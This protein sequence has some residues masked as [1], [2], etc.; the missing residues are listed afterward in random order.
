ME[1]SA[2][3][4]EWVK[5]RR[6]RL[7]LTRAQVARCAGC[8]VSALRK[9]EGDERRP[10]LQLAGLLANCLQIADDTRDIFLQVARGNAP[11]AR[12]AAVADG[13]DGAS[14]STPGRLPHSPVPLVGRETELAA[15][16]RL[17]HAPDSRLVTI[18]GPGGIGKTRLAL[19]VAAG[20]SHRFPQGVAF[21]SLASL[22]SPQSIPLAIAEA[23]GFAFSG[24]LDPQAQLL[25]HLAPQSLLLVLD[26]LEHLLDG[27]GL[28]A[29]IV[30]QAPAV[31]LLVTS[32]ERLNLAGEWVFDLQGLP[33]PPPGQVEET[34][35]YSAVALF[36]QTARHVQASFSLPADE[37]PAV[38]RICQLVEGMPLAIELAAAWVRVLSCA[39]IADEIEGSLDF[40]AGAMRDAPPRQRS[41]RAAFDHSWSLLA[42]DERR[43]L[44]RLSVFQGG[45]R[46]QAAECIAGAT[47]PL[48][49][50]L[51]NKSLLRRAGDGR[52]DLHEVIRQYALAHL[53]ARGDEEVETRSRHSHFYLDLLGDREK[54][55]RS[56][57]LRRTLRELMGEIDNVRAAWAWGIEQHVGQD[58]APAVRTL[59]CMFELAGWLGEGV[60]MLEKAV[61]H[62][63]AHMEDALWRRVAGEALAQQGLLFFRR[64]RF[65]EAKARL[66]ESLEL[67]YPFNEARLLMPALLFYGVINQLDGNLDRSECLM[68]EA[69]SCARAAGEPWY[70]AYAA[71]NL[72]YV[73]SLRGDYQQGYEQMVAS[74]ALWRAVG[75]PRSIALGL[76][77]LCPTMIQLG[78]YAEAEASLQ[79]SLALCTEAG[80][81]WGKGTAL[82]FLGLVA[83]AHAD[84]AEARRR[85]EQSIE[86]FTGYTIGWDI[87]R[88]LIYLGEA[89]RAAGD[90]V[91]A[92][93]TLQD[94]LA[95]A[96]AAHS[97]PLALDAL[98]AL[99]ALHLEGGAPV[100][101]LRL[102]A[103]VLEQSTATHETR[104]RAER[105]FD[106][107]ATQVDA[108]QVCAAREWAA[109]QT[110]ETVGDNVEGGG[111]ES[112]A[113]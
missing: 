101:A 43:L 12:L 76:N 94:A 46:R 69:L 82:R 112:A 67:L 58:V 54:A 44:R 90:T 64:G 8:S 70:E 1:I 83:L 11:V 23:L 80:D 10:S 107:A 19:A 104:T 98:A 34:G 16:N 30:R 5:E 18:V 49:S 9:I 3:F 40:L 52:Y 85:L 17:L 65:D 6:R 53:I 79:E 61:A 95:Q 28:L 37:W 31:K 21:V 56:S 108:P 25:S 63:R 100:L 50:A 35:S 93:H 57:E 78:Y 75:D 48:L 41:L 102:S 111:W 42:H 62:G 81:R 14:V 47:L 66:R 77:F 96:E 27:T 106:E 86:T 84:V 72:G 39:E 22:N 24:P 105:L 20:Q 109:A 55:L 88:S 97:A 73:A 99:A 15:L 110:L 2:S 33:V 26:N 103:F 74:L 29:E 91:S 59:G 4:G 32:R 71:Y 51:V 7:D 68:E 13:E 60:V 92:R 113:R 87:V 45:F 89:T 38:A 36:L